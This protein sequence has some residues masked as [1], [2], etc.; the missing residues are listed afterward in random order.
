M[1][2]ERLDKNGAISRQSHEKALNVKE[3]I[4][5][6]FKGVPVQTPF[7]WLDMKCFTDLQKKVLIATSSI[8]YGNCCSYK[9]IAAAIGSPKAYRFVG[10]TMAINTFP[11]LIPCHRVIR[12]DLSTGQYRGGTDLKKKLI[13]HEA[14]TVKVKKPSFFQ[15]LP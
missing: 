7:E 8:D 2:A 5:D 10:N 11:I 4:T 6:Y 15:P 9:D 3:K 12:S 14:T 13:E 1:I